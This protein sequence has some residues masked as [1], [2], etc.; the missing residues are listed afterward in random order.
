M[1]TTTAKF[2]ESPSD[3]S[4]VKTLIVTEFLKA[5]F[6]IIN[7]SVAKGK[8]EIIYI[9]LF[10]GPGKFEDGQ[11]STPLALLD[12]VNSFEDELRRKI[13]IV[14]NDENRNYINKLKKIVDNH[15]VVQKLNYD[16]EVTNHCA[17]DVNIKAYTSKKCPIF[18]F[19][20][21]WG[22]KG[23]SVT[24]TWE[25]VR[26]IG[27]DCVLFFNSNR[28]IMDI[29]KESQLCHLESIFG[30]QLSEVKK[31]VNN[32]SVDQK[33]KAQRVVEFFS[34]NLLNKV[35]NLGYPGYQLYVLP[36]GFEAD[37]KDKISH[38]ILFI[39]KNHK[40]I[41]EMKKVMVKHSNTN[42]T[43][44]SY[45][46]KNQLQISLFHRGCFVDDEIIKA[47]H[48]CMR[49]DS[50]FLKKTWKIDSLLE[51]LDK[52]NMVL[53]YQAT[54]YLRNELKNVIEQLDKDDLID[55]VIPSISY[56]KRITYDREFKFKKELLV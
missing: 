52:N 21:P 33:N 41:V 24:Q 11:P 40:A 54:P 42:H 12:T 44:L 35:A 32:N 55:V 28:F 7:R 37:D 31:L 16:I 43:S 53:N 17:G 23:V 56:K 9:D 50:S 26:N 29:N 22:Y 36:F 18:S 3:K 49:Q 25:L 48:N 15:E 51:A 8:K 30:N 1:A 2:Y 4:K 38:H 34:K 14:F 6:Q 39:T 27:S 13:R 20:D 19:I 45:D 5:Y 10:C 46:S 47:I